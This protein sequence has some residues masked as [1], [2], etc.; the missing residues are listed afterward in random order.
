VLLARTLMNDPAVVLLDEPSA[1]LDLAGREQ[2]IVAL[3]ELAGH[4]D[5]PPFV[6]VTH[7][8]DDVPT[9]MTHALLLRAGRAHA[10][11]PIDDV[12]DGPTLSS[13]FGLDLRLERRADGRFSAWA[14]RLTER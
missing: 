4:H 8:V 1:G 9:T 10:Q 7:H 11:G 3:D 2:L 14:E 13:C 5:S 6:F 12:L